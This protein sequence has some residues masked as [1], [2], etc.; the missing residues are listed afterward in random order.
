[1]SDESSV[2]PETLRLLHRTIAGVHT[3]FL[4][5]H[6][7]TAAAKVIELN[8]HLTKRG[9]AVPRSVAEP[10]VLMLAPLAPHIAEELWSRLGHDATLAYA[11]FP[12]ADEQWLVAETVE[13][14]IQ[15]NGKVRSRVTV[16]ANA[17]GDAV[18][19]AALAEEK[20]AALL[21]GRPPRKVIVVPGRLVNVVV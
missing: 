15:V 8:N 5:L 19:A 1:V 3:D 4:A 21:D 2:E 9:V 16:P 13:Y 14:P 11:P 12:I 18:R 10:L 6:Y 17:D 20:I 7:N